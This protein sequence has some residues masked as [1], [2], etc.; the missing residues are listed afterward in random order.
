VFVLLVAITIVKMVVAKMVAFAVRM[1][2][3]A[4]MVNAHA[5]KMVNVPV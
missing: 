2:A 5:V 4:K 3:P 1:D